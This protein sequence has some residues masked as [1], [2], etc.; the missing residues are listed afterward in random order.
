M[1]TPHELKALL[2][3][4]FESWQ[5]EMIPA[6]KTMLDQF[7]AQAVNAGVPAA[8]I[9]ELLVFYQISN[10]V[11]CLDGFDFHA[12]NDEIVFEWW[13]DGQELW[14]GQRDFYTL[15]WAANQ[16]CLG[17]AANIS[18]SAAD[19]YDTLAELLNAALR[20]WYGEDFAPHLQN[21]S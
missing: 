3:P 21:L 10:G 12:C 17:D 20:Q 1:D 11:P 19:R 5:A 14:L 9:E 7:Q 8:V 6:T 16:Y 2:T 18:F 4:L 13:D 15:R